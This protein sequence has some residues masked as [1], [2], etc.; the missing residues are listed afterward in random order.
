[1][2]KKK[3]LGIELKRLISQKPL[4]NTEY[5]Q[6]SIYSEENSKFSYTFMTNWC[7]ND[8]NNPL[9]EIRE[10]SLIIPDIAIQLFKDIKEPLLV[11]NN[12]HDFGYFMHLFGGNGL[13]T[14]GLCE[15][16]LPELIKPKKNIK[17]YYGDTTT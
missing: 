5:Y 12:K 3:N 13:I 15:L 11:I 10:P 2:E 4:E 9:I 7:G 8:E 17:T 1:M 16:Y 14:K 6:F